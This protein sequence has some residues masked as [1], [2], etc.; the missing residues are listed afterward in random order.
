MVSIFFIRLLENTE[1]EV[2]PVFNDSFPPIGTLPALEE[3]DSPLVDSISSKQKNV[4]F[5]I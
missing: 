5:K 2:Q 3:D 1:A 4:F